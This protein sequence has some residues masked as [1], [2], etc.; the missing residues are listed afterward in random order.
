MGCGKDINQRADAKSPTLT[1]ETLRCISPFPR[2]EFSHVAT[3]LLL[4]DARRERWD[5][6]VTEPAGD[7]AVDALWES[8]IVRRIDLLDR[9]ATE[10][11]P[12]SEVFAE[13][14]RRLGQAF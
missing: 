8:E 1:S 10:R 2:G 3:G 7:P 4:P 6:F 11:H 13:L 12:A 9:G 14:D 5:W